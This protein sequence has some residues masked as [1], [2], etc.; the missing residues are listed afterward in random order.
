MTGVII[1]ELFHC[2]FYFCFSGI[3]NGW[4]LVHLIMSF[5]GGVTFQEFVEIPKDFGFRAV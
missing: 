3:E 5:K 1:A 4:A 2:F